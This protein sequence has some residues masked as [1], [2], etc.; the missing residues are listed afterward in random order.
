[1]RY[2]PN[3]TVACVI[4]CQGKFLLVEELIN[5]QACFNQPAGHIEAGE[6]ITEAC[7]REVKEETGLSINL[8]GLVKIYQ[9]RAQDG[10]EFVRFT[11]AAT[12]DKQIKAMPEDSA[13]TATHWMSLDE[14]KQAQL[15]LRSPLVLQSIED[16]LL[17]PQNLTP[18]SLLNSDF[19]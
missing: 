8:D 13:I 9:F 19:F 3:T 2:R 1:M 18:L 12:V 17:Q 7:L 4:E 6:S 10:T 16:Y 15:S 14:I 11:F 5:L